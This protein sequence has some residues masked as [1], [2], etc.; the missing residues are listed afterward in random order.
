MQPEAWKTSL[1]DAVEQ[2]DWPALRR[3]A[4]AQPAKTLRYLVGR[5]Y[6][7]EDGSRQNVIEAL[8]EVTSEP[9]VYSV[10]K[11]RELLRRFFWWL[12]DES[13]AVPFG[14]PEAIGVVLAARPELQ[15]EFLPLICAMAHHPDLLQAGPI[16]RGVFW[17]LGRIGR[18]VALC[19]PEAVT[20]VACAAQQH[21][22]AQTRTTAVWALSR[23]EKA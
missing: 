4:G 1:D 8:G 22:D 14:I 18:P 6:T 15:Q 10:E 16:E 5:L 12:N 17:A 11:I 13:G 21:P 7:A 3:A 19:S 23:M 9:G 2:Q 20:A